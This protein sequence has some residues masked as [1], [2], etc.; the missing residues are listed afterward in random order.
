MQ[1]CAADLLRA[2][3]T[4]RERGG[5]WSVGVGV[6]VWEGRERWGRGAGAC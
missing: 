6:V 3:D 2:R 5:S 4:I 1:R